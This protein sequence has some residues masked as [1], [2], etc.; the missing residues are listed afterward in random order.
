[1]KTI[2]DNFNQKKLTINFDE[3]FYPLLVTPPNY[4]TFEQLEISAKSVKYFGAHIDRYMRRYILI[5]KTI[6][7]LRRIP[8]KFIYSK[9]I[10]DTNHMKMVYRA[11][12]ESKVSRK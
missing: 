2:V 6:C 7:T 5:N 3:T 12:I 8:S 10:L 1:M 4:L 11:L 9:Q